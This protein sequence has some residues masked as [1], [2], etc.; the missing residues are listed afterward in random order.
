MDFI[1]SDW[2]IH[3]NLA[4]CF[5]NESLELVLNIISRTVKCTATLG[6][7]KAYLKTG[8]VKMGN[9]TGLALKTNGSIGDGNDFLRL[10]DNTCY[11]TPLFTNILLHE[12]DV[13]MENMR[14]KQ[15]QNVRYVRFGDDFLVSV[16]GSGIFAMGVKEAITAFLSGL[17]LE[18]S[19]A[20][21]YMLKS[22]NQPAQFLNALIISQP[23]F[24]ER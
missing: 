20:E 6:V 9:V 2:F 1:N 24:E 12:L 22:Y 3:P 7:L 19:K 4:L 21:M 15:N 13:F 11:L 8:V 14:A 18:V 16:T 10:R 17:K 5:N 23:L